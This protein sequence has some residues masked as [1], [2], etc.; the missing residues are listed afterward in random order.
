MIDG[1]M[2]FLS[3]TCSKEINIFKDFAVSHLY[4]N[5]FGLFLQEAQ[6]YWYSSHNYL[7]QSPPSQEYPAGQ[8]EQA[9]PV[10]YITPFTKFPALA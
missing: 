3:E 5:K 4:L 1:I 7:A 6:Y 10:W 8:A 2:K 9:V